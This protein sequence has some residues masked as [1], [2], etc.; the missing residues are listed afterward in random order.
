MGVVWQVWY[1]ETTDVKSFRQLW[2]INSLFMACFKEIFDMIIILIVF[3]AWVGQHLRCY[4]TSWRTYDAW[5][6]SI[7][8]CIIYII[9]TAHH[10]W[11]MGTLWGTML[12]KYYHHSKEIRAHLDV[13]GELQCH[14]KTKFIKIGQSVRVFM[15]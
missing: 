11:I 3:V 10:Y 6:S 2:V 14:F 13:S 9:N 8:Q 15:L 5:S 7:L 4:M 12:I 1:C